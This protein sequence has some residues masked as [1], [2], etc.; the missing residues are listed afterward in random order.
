MLS[1][2]GSASSSLLTHLPPG[3]FSGDFN[4]TVVAH[5]SDNLGSTAVT[6]LGI[7]GLPLAIASAPPDQVSIVC[8]FR[9]RLRHRPIHCL[10]TI[11]LGSHMCAIRVA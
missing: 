3:N 5:V 8:D 11:V 9:S 7:D 1:S 10:R 6:S 4:L 2:A